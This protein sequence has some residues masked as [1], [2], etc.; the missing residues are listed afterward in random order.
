MPCAFLSVL[1][2][3]A[4]RRRVRYSSLEKLIY[5]FSECS[6]ISWNKMEVPTFHCACL[7]KDSKRLIVVKSSWTDIVI[8]QNILNFGQKPW[9]ECRV[10]YSQNE[11]KTAD[12]TLEDL[13]EFDGERDAC[14]KAYVLKSYGEFE[15]LGYSSVSIWTKFAI[16]NSRIYNNQQSNQFE[17]EFTWIFYRFWFFV[18]KMFISNFAVNF[19]SEIRSICNYYICWINR[20]VEIFSNWIV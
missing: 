5:S 2:H 14:Y 15:H 1:P 6:C 17:L 4:Y 11:R 9:K 12:F 19:T 16:N 7:L 13:S 8:N 20:I 10:F 18:C 3:V